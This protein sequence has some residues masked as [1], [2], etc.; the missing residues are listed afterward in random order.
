MK[1]AALIYNPRAGS[2]RTEQRIAAIQF[3]L[4][5]AGFDTEPWPTEAPG[6]ATVLAGKAA[7]TGL[8]AVFTHGGDGTLREAAAGLV[9]SS[10]TLAPIPGG[11]VNVVASALGLP[12][13]PVRAAREL[14]SSLPVLAPRMEGGQYHF[15]TRNLVLGM[16][17]DR[18]AASV[19]VNGYRPIDVYGDLNP[20]TMPGQ[21]FID[22][23]VEHLGYAVVQ[24]PF[25][26]PADVHSGL[27]TNRFKTL[28][29]PQFRGVVGLR[30]RRRNHRF[31]WQ[32]GCVGV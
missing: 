3:A 7:R 14:V 30:N 2:W 26:R 1:T 17:V 24:S 25:I 27:L 28:E 5:G 29:L 13:N 12:Q 18:N 9:G 31:R 10:T 21:M 15:H 20:V 8:E 32:F 11:T 22:R 16:Q 4:E 6:H 23:V 19:I